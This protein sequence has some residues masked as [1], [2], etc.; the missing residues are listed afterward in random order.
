MFDL[1]FL[2]LFSFSFEVVWERD[3]GERFLIYKVIVSRFCVFFVDGSFLVF[4]LREIF[5]GEGM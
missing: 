4:G 5:E 3:R 1:L 2:F